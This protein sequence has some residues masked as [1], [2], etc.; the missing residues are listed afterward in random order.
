LGRFRLANGRG[1]LL[2]PAAGLAGEDY[3]VAAELDGDR[4]EAR[5]FLAAATDAATLAEQFAARLEW[6]TS[7]AWDS[8]RGSVR[9]ERHLRLGALVLRTTPAPDPPP[10][11]LREALLD[12]IRRAGLAC[13]PWTRGLRAWQARVGFLGRLLPEEGWPDLSDAAL[14]AGL[15][16]WLGPHLGGLQRLRDLARL[17]LAAIL[18]GCLTWSQ[19]RQLE[20]LAPTHIQV[21][22]GSRIPIDYGPDAPVLAVRLQEM[23][24]AT[25]TPAVA[26]GRQPLVLHLLSPAGR[27]VQVT[28]DLAGFWGTGYLEVKKTLKG[29]YPRHHWP[30]NPLTATPSARA[31][32][33]KR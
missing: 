23:F 12:G 21:P 15:G 11:A 27:P 32:P 8:G 1:A 17:D 10:E 2:D 30:D 13:L 3:L 19:A 26:G 25:Q 7:V 24:G 29:R 22:S 6:T 4:R 9:A 18:R 31:K 28:R 14:E 16:T 33:R 5:I 20:D